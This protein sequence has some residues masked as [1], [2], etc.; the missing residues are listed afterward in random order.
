MQ[1]EK[2]QQGDIG[3]EGRITLKHILQKWDGVVEGSCEYS[4]ELSGSI[5]C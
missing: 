2:D 4:N 5:K 1:K 3:V